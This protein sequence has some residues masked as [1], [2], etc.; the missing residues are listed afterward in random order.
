MS[1]SVFIALFFMAF[2]QSAYAKSSDLKNHRGDPEE[3][4]FATVIAKARELGTRPYEAQKVRSEDLL[5]EIDYDAHWKISFRKSATLELVPGVPIQFFHLGRFFKQPVKL[6]EVADGVSREILYSPD[7]FDMPHDSPAR[8]LPENL[9]FAGFRVM[10]EDLKTDWVSF[11]GASYFRTDGQSRQYGQSARG[12]ALNTGLSMPEE[13]PRFTEFWFVPSASTD[14]GLVV[15]ALLDSPS[16]A[17]A[18]RM[19]MKNEEGSGQVMDVTSHLFFRKSVERLGIAPLTSMYWYSESNR[20]KGRDWRP[21]VHDTD[22]LAMISQSGEM[23]WRPLN[24]PSEVRT[25]TF[26]ADNVRGFGLAQRDREFENFQDDGVFYD[27]RPSVWIEPDEPFGKGV[28]QL[29]E[30]PTDDEIYDNIVA[31]FLPD[32]LPK[33]GDERTFS[34]Q[35]TWRDQHPLPQSG[36]RVFA[37]RI[38]Q[39]GIPGQPRPK[40][41][42][43]VVVE[44]QGKSLNGIKKKDEVEA[45]VE[46]S[47]GEPI[48]LFVQPVVGTDRWR[49]TFDVK[50]DGR[51]PVEAR[52]FLKGGDDVL[53][54]T[55]LGQLIA[56]HL[57]L[58]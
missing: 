30:I 2:V 50:I 24:N 52:A 31:Y 4:S 45:V 15:Y 37:T 58:E 8:K 43:K 26:R 28:V 41:Q 57:E 10:R 48:N 55:W 25:S 1:R 40:D 21:E 32:E 3:F 9:G 22:G 39:G 17:G 35:M 7:Y 33:A 6:N 5:E 20:L 42:M 19:H 46:L 51:D 13:F 56:E 12:L 16:V 54:E 53:S 36:A 14:D 38:G 49:L 47:K 27:R 34:Y 11:L 18:Y 44:F 23:I 29:V